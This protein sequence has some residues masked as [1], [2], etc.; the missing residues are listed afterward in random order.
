MKVFYLNRVRFAKGDTTTALKYAFGLAKQDKGIDTITLLVLQ[1]QQYD[2]FLSEISFKPIHYKNHVANIAGYKI[3]IHTVKTYNPNYQFQGHPQSEI[4]IAVG[5]PPKDLIRFEDFSNIKYW[6]IVPWLI[7]EN[8]EWLSIFEAEDLETGQCI[9]APNASD[10]R[11]VNAI[12]WLRETSYP[13]EGYHNPLDEDRLHQMANAINHYKIPFDYAST[14]YC[15]LHHGLIPS[16]ARNTAE[17]F[18][19]AQRRAFAIKYNDYGKAFLKEMM[20]TSHDD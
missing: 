1:Q 18:L 2:P 12:G 19:M 10:E 14:V 7:E 13:N 9:A 20:E 11:I 15:G 3:Q 6:I 8:A 17:A 5:V 16:A 4:L